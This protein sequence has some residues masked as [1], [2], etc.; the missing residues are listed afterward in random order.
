[1]HEVGASGIQHLCLVAHCLFHGLQQRFVLIKAGNQAP[2]ARHVALAVG[3]RAYKGYAAFFL[4]GQ[5]F[6]IVLQKDECLGGNVA[7][8]STV[9]RR[10]DLFLG[11]LLVAIAIRVGKESELPLGLQDASA[12]GVDSGFR[13]LAFSY[14]LCQRAKITVRHH[15]HVGAG[16]Q[17]KCRHGLEIAQTVVHHLGDSSIVGHDHALEA[18]HATQHIGKQPAVGG[19]RNALNGVEGGHYAHGAS[20]DGS[21]VGRHV[22]VEHTPTAHVDRVII[23]SR[24]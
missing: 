21:L 18:P 7:G 16:V 5:H 23:A 8:L 22:I 6:A 10:E 2:C 3:Q 24:L 13:H 15:V 12:G 4:Q 20:I 11:T 1:M 14:R 9:G 17:G 19:G